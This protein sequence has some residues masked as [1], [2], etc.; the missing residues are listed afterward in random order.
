MRRHAKASIAGLT[1]LACLVLG[2]ALASATAPTV[3]IDAPSAVEFNSVHVSGDVDPADQ[4]VFGC[5]FQYVNDT[6]YLADQGGGGD[7]FGP[8]A[9][10]DCDV[11]PTA[12]SGAT[13]VRADLNGL[14]DDTL[15]HVRLL[16]ENADGQDVSTEETFKTDAVT[17]PVVTIDTPLRRLHHRQTLRLG[18]SRGHR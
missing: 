12:G 3:T 11:F 15:Y 17:A 16:A 1:L 8:A 13:D 9:S 10:A 14:E 7:G 5:R 6:D 2:V 18:R 4:D